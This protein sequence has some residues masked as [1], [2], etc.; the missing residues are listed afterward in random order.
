[1]KMLPLKAWERLIS[2]VN[3]LPR[4][5]LCL[6]A[7]AGISLWP[8][9]PAAQAAGTGATMTLS[10]SSTSVPADG[11]SSTTAT[12]TVEDSTG[13]GVSGD[14][15][16]LSSTDAGETITNPAT[17]NGNGT[18]TATITSSTTVGTATITA[19]DSTSS[20]TPATATLTQTAGPA[21]TVTVA[22]NPTAVVANGTSTTTA[23]ATVKDA[24][25]HLL[26]N[27]TNVVFGSSDSGEVVGTP[28]NTGNG[29]YTATITSS[30]TVGTPTITASDGT[31]SGVATLTQTAGPAATV[32]VALSPTSIIANGT[33]TT[34]ATATVKDAGGNLLPSENVTFAS[35]DTGDKVSA[36]TNAGSGTYTATITS[37][38]TV[39]TPTITATDGT[40]SGTATL[41]QTTDPPATVT[42]A[43]NPTSIIAN[44]TATTTATATVKDAGGNL[45]PS[46][47]VTFSSSDTGDKVSTTTNAGSGTYTATITSSTTVGTPT[48]T[49]TDGTVSGTATLTQTV[50][51]A[52]TLTVA[53]SPVVILANGVSTAVATATVKD[54]QGHLLT[55]QD[56]SFK[57][58]D[59][60]QFFGQVSDN[61][62]GTYSVQVRSSTTVGS[63]TITA[64]DSSVSPS[65]AGEG[66]LVQAAG[67]STTS[68]VASSS[69]LVTN[70]T[71]TLFATVNPGPGSPAGAITFDDGGAPIANCAAMPITPANPGATCQTSF[72]ASTSPE[73]LTAVF[74][75]NSSSTAPG[76][77]G[78]AT[79]TV[80]PDST[81]VSLNA[82]TTVDVGQSTT[83][84]ATV[85]PPASR[86]GPV[87]PSGSVEFVDNGSPIASCLD[88]ALV[89]LS[90]T[91]TLTY[92]ATGTH[93]ITARYGG[94]SNFTG[95]TAP[96]QS[97]SVVL[98]PVHVVGLISATMQWTF[99]YTPTYTK[100]AVLLV[101]WVSSD[102]TVLIECHGRGCPFATHTG[103][104]A[105]P[106][107][108]GKKGKPK[109]PSG[110]SVNLAAPFQKDPLHP[111]AT[112]I[113]MIR[114]P[115]WVGK[116]YKFT[117]RAGN[118]PIVQV[119][120]LAPGGNR[121][122]VGC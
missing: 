32:T 6:L 55:G 117:I 14:T 11:T 73:R 2:S 30:T 10:L 95:S 58:T 62:N 29:T 12:V 40:A 120:C 110:G 101:N 31:A 49:A 78:A 111:R 41:T 91:C 44:G 46:S 18:Y 72:A 102:A 118:N 119:S 23:T 109:C 1:M 68:L 59:P 67:P 84:T 9:S 82:S 100:V 114:R 48:I 50:G 22:L 60:V 52:A 24:E 17:D 83:Y 88:Q 56:V 63:A 54:A 21:A 105:K 69:A 19:T 108:C 96:A 87:E 8:G 28:T 113:V 80:T 43:L 89:K 35:S 51:S 36:T 81:S 27:E 53:V 39:G 86:S 107:R 7:A 90:A 106:K 65:V 57:S 85:A 66:T 79:I 34:A 26:S 4:L 64:T 121:P 38:T 45:L 94:D 115:G 47:T 104:V 74:V 99:D 122:G 33:A 13:A 97:V 61:G 93:S 116:Y 103:R 71:V 20:V 15:V 42:V 92:G 70:Q 76:S 75:P 37:S 25:G 98:A 77:T 5:W 16:N 3:N 112:V